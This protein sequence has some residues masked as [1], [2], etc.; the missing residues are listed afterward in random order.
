MNRHGLDC[1][2]ASTAVQAEFLKAAK[3]HL[4]MIC[5]V[6]AAEEAAAV[7]TLQRGERYEH[8][9]TCAAVDA[10]GDIC[11]RATVRIYLRR[12]ERPLQVLPV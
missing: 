5:A 1:K 11:F 10:S 9:F 6:T 4:T 12:I 7:A 3:T 2:V 8:D